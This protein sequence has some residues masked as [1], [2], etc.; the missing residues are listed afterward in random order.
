MRYA[1]LL[2][3]G[4][5]VLGAAS[6][7]AGDEI[8]KDASKPA[9]PPG[10]T[11]EYLTK[12]GELKEAVTFR[13]DSVGLVTPERFG[14]E[15]VWVIEPAGDWTNQS[16]ARGKVTAKQLA[17]LARHLATQ[18]FYSLPDTL[19]HKVP[20]IDEGYQRVVIGFGKKSATFNLQ[21]GSTPIDY[22]PKPGDPLA[23]AWSR[24]V[25][26]EHDLSRLLTAGPPPDAKPPKGFERPELILEGSAYG[27]LYP[28]F[29]D[30]DGDGKIDMV[31]GT[32]DA[33]L[34]VYRNTGTNVRPVYT[35]PAWLDETIPS[36]KVHG[37]QG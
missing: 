31:V 15:E 30:I 6:N 22:L 37:I 33:R 32:W 4:V 14:K 29:A 20:K 10:G 21:P 23:S 16:G 9:N 2:S 34:L 3:F 1:I 28:A 8:A 17:A 27:R 5:A 25:A 11:G 35:K 36:A 26:L 18:D 12:D 19:G 24:F 7:L 13:K